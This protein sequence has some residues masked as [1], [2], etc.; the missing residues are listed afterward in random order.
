MKRKLLLWLFGLLLTVQMYAQNRTISGTVKDAKGEALIGVNVTGKGTTIGT[1]TDIDGKYTLEL[2]KEVG[3]LVFS[4]VGYTTL[5]KAVTAKT[6]DAVL[7]EEGKVLED[8]VVTALG[9][10]KEQKTLSYSATT[11]SN[12]AITNVKTLSALESL[13]GKVSGLKISSASGQPGAS[14]RVVIRGY[15]SISGNSSPLYVIDGV[16][17]NN[18]TTQFRMG[19]GGVDKS[20]DFGNQINEINS[21]DIESMTVLKGSAASALYGTRGSA[22]VILITTKSGKTKDKDAEKIHVDYSL[23]LEGSKVLRVPKVQDIYGQGWFFLHYTQENGNWGPKYTNLPRPWGWGDSISYGGEPANSGVNP[24]ILDLTKNYSFDKN[25]FKNA[26]ETGLMI[27]NSI[28]ITGSSKALYYKL[29]YSQI[30]SNGV[31]PGTSDSYKRHTIS[32]RIGADYNKFGFDVAMNYINKNQSAVEG[33][34]ESESYGKTFMQELLQIPNDIP[35]NQIKDYNDIHFN[36]DNYFTPYATN[37]FFNLNQNGNIYSENRF[38]TSVELTY[39]PIK[40]LVVKSR[41]GGD[42][43]FGNIKQWGAIIDYSKNPLSPL[44]LELYDAVPNNTIGA[45]RERTFERRQL[46][47]DFIATYN[48][49]LFKN[50]INIDLLAGFN[51]N[52]QS[53]KRLTSSVEGLTLPNVYTLTNSNNIPKLGQLNSLSR[54]I[55]LYGQFT[56]GLKSALYL[57]YTA[58]NDWN[59]TLPEK[60]RS[61]FYQGGSGSFVLT[62]LF[63]KKVK[64]VSLI[65]LRAGYAKTGVA[66]APYLVNDVYTQATMVAGDYGTTVFPFDGVNGFEPRTIIGNPNLKPE[67]AKELEVGADLRFF[68]ERLNIDFAYYDKRQQNMIL[69]A[70]IAPST[71]AS[72]QNINAGSIQNRGY[73]LLVDVTP[74][75]F[76]NFSWN[77]KYNF[78]KNQSKVL[79]LDPRLGNSYVIESAYNVELRLEKGQPVGTFYAPDIQK[80]DDG[81]VIVNP[82]TGIPKST[83]ELTRVGDMNHKYTMGL[84]T[85]ISFKGVTIG[86]QLDFRKGGLFWSYTKQLLT[87]TGADWQTTFNDRQIMIYP[88][89]VIAS[90]APDG[91]TTYT[92]NT[93]PISKVAYWQ[94]YWNAQNTYIERENILDKT[95]L[96]LRE[97]YINYSLPAKALKATKLNNI[98]FSLIARNIGL[99]TPASNHHVDPESTNFGTGIEGEFGEFGITPSVGS[100]GF[101]FKAG[102]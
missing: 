78:N 76:K 37:P 44:S 58:R 75:K 43:S 95:F 71:G 88:N 13:T 16:P 6:I 81:K 35:I 94:Q 90:V 52:G 74:L 72:F 55:G 68:D 61:F 86:G 1:V 47:G 62:E 82:T 100:I 57:T 51:V 26:F 20:V 66:T 7:N 64:Y 54:A 34:Q 49:Y 80:T 48:K 12:A 73:E 4:Y 67:F 32:A 77:I 33:G 50:W 9:V 5:E 87:F 59:S 85:S 17:V 22:G 11:I 63:K 101:T 2:P 19:D 79:D 25:H 38:F 70:N 92:E 3:T 84:E 93:T 99:W 41:F 28:G 31:I 14:T 89:S 23:T 39:K 30:K 102:F 27:N 83:T 98:S 45:V 8:V 60:N 15:S 42:F 18:P 29:N 97:V 21:D 10:K 96:K 36:T 69:L 56:L 65:K 46:N 40:D 24:S 53:S 91:T